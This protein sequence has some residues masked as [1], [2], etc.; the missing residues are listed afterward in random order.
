MWVYWTNN[1]ILGSMIFMHVENDMHHLTVT[2]SLLSP[3]PGIPEAQSLAP[4]ATEHPGAEVKSGWTSAPPPYSVKHCVPITDQIK[5][6]QFRSMGV[7][8]STLQP[9][10]MQM[11]HKMQEVCT[12]PQLGWCSQNWGV[13]SLAFHTGKAQSDNLREY[14]RDGVVCYG[15][16]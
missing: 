5:T 12:W 15:A 6:L 2:R 3:E 9:P 7:Q 1:S 13:S 14:P 8:A 4:G 10:M 11:L 16:V